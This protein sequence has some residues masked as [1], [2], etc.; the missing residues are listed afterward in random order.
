MRSNDHH[1]GFG[2][3]LSTHLCFGNILILRFLNEEHPPVPRKPAHQMLR[4]LKNETP[5]QMREAEHIG[6][7]FDAP[8]NI[9]I[10]AIGPSVGH[11]CSPCPDSSSALCTRISSWFKISCAR[12]SYTAR[13]P[14]GSA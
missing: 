1:A 7:V 6:R 12:G 4:A 9:L 14:S 13:D 5:S 2:A 11:R 8:A 3:H 10:H